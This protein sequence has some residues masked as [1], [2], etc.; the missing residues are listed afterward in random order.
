MLKDPVRI[1]CAKWRQLRRFDSREGYHQYRFGLT[2]GRWIIELEVQLM[3]FGQ[4]ERGDVLVG[5]GMKAAHDPCKIDNRSNVRAVIAT[6]SQSCVAELPDQGGRS[7]RSESSHHR[8]ATSVVQ[9]QELNLYSFVGI[10]M[11]ISIVKKNAVMMIDFA[12]DA[13]RNDGKSPAESIYQGA[14]VRFRPIMMTTMAALMG[15]L[16]IAIGFGTGA[17]PRRGLG[18]AV[19][20]GLLFS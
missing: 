1:H 2:E 10:I 15:T 17:D 3:V 6:T 11:L 18:L 9:H 19:V 8:L 13:E 4:C 20:G 5:D 16:P 7:A 12:L 14:L